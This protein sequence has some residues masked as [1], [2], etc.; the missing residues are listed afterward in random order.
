MLTAA[1]VGGRLESVWRRPLLQG[2]DY[3]LLALLLVVGLVTHLWLVTHTAVPARDS[4]GYARIALNWSDPQAGWS[5]EGRRSRI[6]VIR[7]AEQPPGYP[8]MIWLM[9][10]G[11]RVWVSLPLTERVLLAAQSVNALSAVLLVIPM[12]LLGRMLFGWQAAAAGTLLFQILPTPTRVTS[13]G[14]S[15]G[16]FLL[17]MGIALA[18]GVWAVRRPL[19]SRFLLCGWMI[20]AAYLVRPEGLLLAATLAGVVL[21]TGSGRPLKARLGW[22]TALGVGVTLIGLPYMLLIGKLTNK[23]TGKHLTNPFNDQLPPIWRGQPLSHLSPF[24]WGGPGLWAEWWN[25]QQDAHRNRT[26]WA[27]QAVSK[28]LIKS[29]HYGVAGFAAIGLAVLWRRLRRGEPGT[30]LLVATGACYFGLLLYLAARIGYV[31]ERHTLL[32]NMLGCLWAAVAIRPVADWLSTAPLIHHLVIWPQ[33]MPLG[34][35][36]SLV[37]TAVPPTVQ[38]LHNHREGHKQAGRWLASQLQEQDWV[39]DPFCWAEWYAGR[40]L[41]RTTEYRGRP[42]RA[43]VVVEE[44]KASPH[45]RLP[46]WEQAQQLARH[47]QAVFRWPPHAN[48]DQPRVVVYRVDDVQ[49]IQRILVTGRD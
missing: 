42:Q 36:S 47:G 34:L 28:E 37:V 33:W 49:A 17:L 10:K 19:V 40:T 7:S 15:E 44:G 32:L 11:L 39:V 27:L 22:I 18:L 14:V 3:G 45:S 2:R 12:Y 46:Q 9:D 41:Y 20:G 31:S 26:A 25:P 38:P 4:L 13:D 1:E 5:G 30:F 23:P 48:T 21:I 8:L 29:L 6:D 35:L 24:R 43:W 16:L